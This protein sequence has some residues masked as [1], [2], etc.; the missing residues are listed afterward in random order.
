M[1]GLS[2]IATLHATTLDTRPSA[3]LTLRPVGRHTRTGSISLKAKDLVKR[4]RSLFSSS[5]SST[6]APRTSV[7]SWTSR[8]EQEHA[9]GREKVQS[10]WISQG[11]QECTTDR[12]QENL[13]EAQTSFRRTASV[14][15]ARGP[16]SSPVERTASE[17]RSE[18]KSQKSGNAPQLEP[19]WISALV[20][21]GYIFPP[22]SSLHPDMDRSSDVDVAPSRASSILVHDLDSSADAPKLHFTSSLDSDRSA[23]F[24]NRS[25]HALVPSATKL[26]NTDSAQIRMVRLH[27]TP[28]IG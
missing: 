19:S 4:S 11:E 7:S 12:T 13:N 22:R 6:S 15:L 25:D 8:S 17:R 20:E 1:D 24:A 23:T 21:N 16:A 26:A 3:P 5:S 10:S 27:C 2:F 28:R 18:T 9:M 14:D